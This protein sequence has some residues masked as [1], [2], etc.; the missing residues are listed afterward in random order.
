MPSSVVD[1]MKEHFEGTY[2]AEVKGSAAVYNEGTQERG[3]DGEVH[4]AY[5]VDSVD[6]RTGNSGLVERAIAA[7]DAQQAPQQQVATLDQ[8]APAVR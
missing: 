3:A 8:S 5:N 4:A 1:E 6:V 7:R 2:H